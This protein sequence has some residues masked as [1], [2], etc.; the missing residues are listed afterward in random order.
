LLS[1]QQ[2]T[3]RLSADNPPWRHVC[4]AVGCPGVDLLADHLPTLA[5]PCLPACL[6]VA[7]A[8][9]HLS[10]LEAWDLHPP[11][12]LL[13]S[14]SLSLLSLTPALT[15]CCP[16]LTGPGSTCSE[17]TRLWCQRPEHC[18]PV[19]VCRPGKSRGPSRG[20]LSRRP[21]T[22]NNQTQTKTGTPNP[23]HVVLILNNTS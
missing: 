7:H 16:V 23:N 18:A 3:L 10:R 5:V 11:P 14:H 1:L 12:T 9:L 2:Y 15:S 17:Q 6:P 4:A 22:Q 21:S 8:L 20:P 13:L 19:F